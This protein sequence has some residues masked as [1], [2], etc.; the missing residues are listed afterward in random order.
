METLTLITCAKTKA[1]TSMPAREMYLSSKLFRLSYQQ[2]EADGF[3]IAIL[4]AKYGLL[5]PDAVIS[6]YDKTIKKMTPKEVKAWAEMVGKQFDRMFGTLK[7]D[8]VVFLASR[9]YRQPIEE[10]L[11]KRGIRSRVHP[12]WKGFC[13][14]AFG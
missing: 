10:V 3:R 7:I 2:A 1:K 4:S 9:D 12:K 6:P 11:R 14:E 5:L 8:E 13:D